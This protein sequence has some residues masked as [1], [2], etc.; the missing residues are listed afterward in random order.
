MPPLAVMACAA[1]RAAQVKTKW[2][3]IKAPSAVGQP[4]GAAVWA[5]AAQALAQAGGQPLRRPARRHQ[6]EALLTHASSGRGR[7]SASTLR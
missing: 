3:V 4:N 1:R 2:V 7:G 5:A 6:A